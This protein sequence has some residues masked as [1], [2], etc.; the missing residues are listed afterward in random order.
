[1]TLN[2]IVLPIVFYLSKAWDHVPVYEQIPA[3][4]VSIVCTLLGYYVTY[5]TDKSAQEI[6]SMCTGVASDEA[7]PGIAA[8]VKDCG[9][10]L[11]DLVALP[12]RVRV[13]LDDV[14]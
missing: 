1:M 2:C 9:A 14:G 5:T 3:I 12:H 10:V 8:A 6:A 11:P 7:A 13:A 4:I